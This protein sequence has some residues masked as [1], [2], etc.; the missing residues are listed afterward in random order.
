MSG[1]RSTVAFKKG[2][3]LATQAGDLSAIH[4][5]GNRLIDR[6][7]VECKAYRDLNYPGLLTNR[8]NLVEFWAEALLQARRYDKEPMLIA[9]QNQMPITVCLTT[10]GN[11]V[12]GRAVRPVLIARKINMRIVLF[13]DF[14]ANALVPK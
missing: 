10:D 9:K 5:I 3:R 12:F 7:L 14:I 8:G 6:F 4:S 13:D 11:T 1:G 2:K